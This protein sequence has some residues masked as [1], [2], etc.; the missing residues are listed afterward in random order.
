MGRKWVPKGIQGKA[1]DLT[2][3]RGLQLFPALDVR[4]PGLVLYF[5]VR[6]PS[7]LCWDLWTMPVRPVNG[8]RD[9]WVSSPVCVTPGVGAWRLGL[10]SVR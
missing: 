4:R 8:A 5:R 2:Q 9:P 3:T 1:C 10:P 6:N 7:L